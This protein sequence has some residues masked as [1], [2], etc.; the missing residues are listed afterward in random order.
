MK[1]IT[2][3]Q[4]VGRNFYHYTHCEKDCK[5]P[6]EYQI[7]DLK[8]S[9]KEQEEA[10]QEEDE[11]QEELEEDESCDDE[12]FDELSVYL[13]EDCWVKRFVD[14]ED[15]NLFYLLFLKLDENGQ[16]EESGCIAEEI[17]KIGFGGFMFMTPGFDLGVSKSYDILYDLPDKA[18]A[19][20]RVLES[21]GAM[22]LDFKFRGRKLPK[23]FMERWGDG[24]DTSCYTYT[25]QSAHRLA[26]MCVNISV[27]EKTG[28]IKDFEYTTY[29]S[30]GDGYGDMFSRPVA[31]D[32]R[33]D[34]AVDML[35]SIYDLYEKDE[36]VDGG[37]S[38]KQ[39]KTK[40]TQE[41]DFIP[42]SRWIDEKDYL[43]DQMSKPDWANLPEYGVEVFTATQL[44]CLSKE[45]EFELK[46]FAV[47]EEAKSS[48][49]TV[50]QFFHCCQKMAM[51]S[52]VFNY[53]P[54]A[55]WIGRLY[56][57]LFEDYWGAREWYNQAARNGDGQGMYRVG[58]LY[59]NE[60]IQ[61]ENGVS[62]RRCFEDA[63]KKN[64]RG[65]AEILE[66]RFV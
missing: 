28:A 18:S 10:E 37:N 16:I 66:T 35:L 24:S 55:T 52:A 59:L 49:L 21:D 2:I 5:Q 8:L 65:A 39:I 17:R 50:D 38:S 48:E 32:D 46:Y 9:L 6:A 1:A 14:D 57:E 44:G 51:L 15:F 42:L 23:G 13:P 7:S 61:P 62:V 45:T 29:Q 43:K 60:K 36:L 30:S 22:P 11:E 54:A 27:D 33:E 47:A 12:E 53:G 3:K 34:E 25:L 41:V 64:V 31:I 63:A 56:D 4:L 40:N 19:E 20:L 26:Y 58:L